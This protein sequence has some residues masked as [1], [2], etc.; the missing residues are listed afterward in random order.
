[1]IGSMGFA[2]RFRPAVLFLLLFLAG[3]GGGDPFQHA[4]ISGK[5]TY[6]DGSPIVV[7]PLILRFVP[8]TAPIAAKTH[9]RPG[10]AT[11][12]KDGT[13]S[14]A[15]T[16]KFNDGLVKG[17]HK[18]I[19]VGANGAP[20]PPS[21]VPPEYCDPIKTPLEVDTA[22]LPFDLKVRKPQ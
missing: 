13:F 22:Q 19:L 12:S 20:I 1:M 10:T 3:C 4:S 5:I 9:P 18:V 15:T 8:Q 7:D 14:S 16:Y 6:E 21:I 11:V 17:K 2:Q